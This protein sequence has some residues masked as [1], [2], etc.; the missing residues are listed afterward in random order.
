[1]A[2]PPIAHIPVLLAEVLAALRPAPG[3]AVADCTVGLG[4][5]AAA[6][7]PRIM[8]GGRLV[9]LD[10]DGGNLP[11][12]RSRLDQELAQRLAGGGGAVILRQANFAALPTVL[13]EAGLE[14]LDGLLADLG[15]CSAQIDD[16]ARGF[17]Y[18]QDGPLDMR[19]DP[20]R[21]RTAAQLVNTLPPEELETALRELGDEEDA[22]RIVEVIVEARQRRPIRTT[23][24]LMALVCQ[25]RRFTLRRAA[26]ARLHPAARSFQALRMLVNR[27]LPSLER[28]LAVL[29]QVL[30]PGGVAVIISFHSGEDRLVK[31]ALALGKEQGT[32]ADIAPG[33]VTA[34]EAEQQANPRSRSAKLRWAV[35]A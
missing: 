4:G 1:M 7:L 6:I 26:G 11:A 29:P 19:M 24:E 21:G 13:A 34:T 9:G 23:F 33:P 5:H 10:R 14:Q 2:P 15:L 17:S 8:P 25:A 28:L 22:P 35:R 30:R 31:R 18:R 12:A 32:Y 20:T 3:H 16:P 27:E